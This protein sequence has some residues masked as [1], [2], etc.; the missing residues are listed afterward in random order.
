MKFTDEPISQG[1]SIIIHK[2]IRSD[3]NMTALQELFFAVDVDPVS[4]K[5]KI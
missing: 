2:K 1:Y 3:L 5:G 4:T